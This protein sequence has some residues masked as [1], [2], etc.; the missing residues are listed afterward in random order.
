MIG[1]ELS[2]LETN[3]MKAK[4]M[5]LFGTFHIGTRL[6]EWYLSPVLN[7]LSIS[8][9]YILDA[10]CGRGTWSFYLARKFPNAQVIGLDKMADSLSVCNFLAEKTSFKNVSFIQREFLDMDYKNQFNLV[11]SINSLHYSLDSDLDVLY[12][13]YEALKA[14]GNLVLV[15]PIARELS[16][17][18]WQ[19]SCPDE[20][21]LVY[22]VPLDKDKL[23][24]KYTPD[25]ICSK[26]TQV[27][28]KIL[29]V[30]HIIGRFGAFSKE[31]SRKI[32]SIPLEIT[33]YPFLLTIAALDLFLIK[34]RGNYILIVAKKV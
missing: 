15:V 2:Y 6:M 3:I 27:G 20:T 1:Q 34:N 24:Q 21:G 5:R 7:T 9:E 23:A 28:F 33:T 18:F 31:V 4:L 25:E 30:K 17:Y 32:Q 16:F 29:N 11:L 22:G 13:F 14:N 8:P 10:G 26:V 19:S 12:R